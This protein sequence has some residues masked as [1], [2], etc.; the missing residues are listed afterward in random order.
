MNPSSPKAV[1]MVT[2]AVITMGMITHM[3]MAQPTSMVTATASIMRINM[4]TVMCT[5]RTASTT[6][7]EQH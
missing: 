1:L 6:T 5:V 3:T 2:T 4:T 7:D